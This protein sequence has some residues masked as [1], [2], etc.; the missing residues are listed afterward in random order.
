MTHS[1]K[2]IVALVIVLSAAAT[3]LS[4][5]RKSQNTQAQAAEAKPTLIVAT[6]Q[7]KIADWPVKLIANGNIAPWQEA[8]VGA[9]VDGLK[10]SA[11]NVNVG[12]IVHKG[13]VLA[14][15]SKDAVHQALAE[16]GALVVE[17]EAVLA[18]AQANADRARIIQKSGALPAQQINQLLVAE[19]T[20]EAKL[21][22][23]KARRAARQ[24]QLSYTQVLAPDDGV[25]SSRTA[26][27]GAV[28]ANG[29]ELFRLIR[30]N[31]LEWRA[32]V[33]AAELARIQTGTEAVLTL[34]DSQQIRGTVRMVAPTLDLKTRNALV[35]VD[36]PAALNVKA[37]M[38][39][40][41]EFLLGS[42]GALTVPHLAV[43]VRDG[44]NYVFVVDKDSRSRQ[45]KVQ[46]GRRQDGRIEILQGV[47]EDM[48]IVV[49]GAGF[50][51]DGDL[52][53]VQ[54]EQADIARSDK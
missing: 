20:A 24:L 19:R 25:I 13:Q 29:D 48:A 26:T 53:S 27:L 10:L 39:V 28:V 44:F 3:S 7:A 1:K 38:F 42:T 4:M 16:Q 40:S 35:Y 8:I 6:A 43:V 37:G 34:P 47:T 51:N 12:D 46:V 5:S 31:R 14:E 22:A 50:L 15:F 2:F 41:G 30:K 18:E 32:E 45:V 23:A 36:L 17:A 49:S 54:A 33:T 52:V 9:E 21:S 11:V